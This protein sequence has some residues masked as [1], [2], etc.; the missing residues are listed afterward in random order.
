MPRFS[1]NVTGIP[2]SGNKRT[3]TPTE[4]MNPTT[5]LAITSIIDCFLV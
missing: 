5:V 4:I 2:I 1:P 3:D